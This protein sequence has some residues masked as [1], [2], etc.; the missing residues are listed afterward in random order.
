MKGFTR[1]AAVLVAVMFVLTVLPPF[2]PLENRRAQLAQMVAE[3]LDE[4][5]TIG[6]LTASLLPTPH[7]TAS[8]VSMGRDDG[9]KIGSVVIRPRVATLFA[10]QI[11]VRNAE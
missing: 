11:A 7:F 4:P 9:V 5:V 10:E 2:V 1:G 3:R 6:K 8:D